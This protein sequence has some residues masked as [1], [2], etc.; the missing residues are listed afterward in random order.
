MRC[1]QLPAA[2][3]PAP[4]LRP[5]VPRMLSI[6]RR[7]GPIATSSTLSGGCPTPGGPYSRRGVRS[8]PPGGPY[9]RRG[10]CPPAAGGPYSRRRVCPP[11][12]LRR[13]ETRCAVYCCRPRPGQEPRLAPPGTGAGPCFAA[14]RATVSSPP[15]P[16]APRAVRCCLALP[17][18]VAGRAGP[19]L[20]SARPSAGA[21]AR[22]PTRSGPEPAPAPPGAGCSPLL[23]PPSAGA[24]PPCD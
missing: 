1:F 16:A 10:V 6:L 13:G 5:P 4:R 14:P 3:S 7:R 20:R 2:A 9:S 17:G 15:A 12:R 18:A 22:C 19:E 11:P 8:P 21:V 23:V 24:C